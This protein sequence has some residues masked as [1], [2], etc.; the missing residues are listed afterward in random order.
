MQ[1]FAIVLGLPANEVTTNASVR[2]RVAILLLLHPFP[3]Q[4]KTSAGQVRRVN[5]T[6]EYATNAV[7]LLAD[8]SFD[9]TFER[10]RLG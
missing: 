9:H 5:L 8:V 1:T 2:Q 3:H 7:P 10:R 6:I 4:C